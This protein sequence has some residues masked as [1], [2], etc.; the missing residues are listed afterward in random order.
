MIRKGIQTLVLVC[1]YHIPL[2]VGF[3]IVT[4]YPPKYSSAWD[5]KYEFVGKLHFEPQKQILYND[6]TRVF[7][8][9]FKFCQTAW[10]IMR[11]ILP[12][13][14]CCCVNLLIICQLGPSQEKN[15]TNL[16]YHLLFHECSRVS[17]LPYQCIKSMNKR[18]LQV[19]QSDRRL[20]L[21]GF[22]CFLS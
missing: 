16:N 4:N 7:L 22:Q 1:N 15:R 9:R 10:L 13:V 19:N 2:E 5:T 12:F 21:S 14:F 18:Y 3:N 8:F 6:H 17:I 11:Q 20:N